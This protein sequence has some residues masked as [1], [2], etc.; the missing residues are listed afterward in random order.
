[1]EL[2]SSA[3]FMLVPPYGLGYRH[4][5]REYYLTTF[6]DIC[7]DPDDIE[8]WRRIEQSPL[9]FLA[10]YIWK[11]AVGLRYR[12]ESPVRT[13]ERL[14]FLFIAPGL[15]DHWPSDYEYCL[16]KHSRLRRD[17]VLLAPPQ[18]EE[19]HAAI[20]KNGRDEIGAHVPSCALQEDH[21]PPTHELVYQASE[22]AANGS[23]AS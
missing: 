10:L 13:L 14:V 19:E 1:M 3:L 11:M 8:H 20:A 4:H 15:T 16:R 2:T 9:S 5:T 22:P 18:T 23:F 21:Y 17:G 7:S 6:G 12:H